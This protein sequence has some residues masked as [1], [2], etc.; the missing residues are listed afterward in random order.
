MSESAKNKLEVYYIDFSESGEKT[1]RKRIDGKKIAHAA[2]VALNPVATARFIGGLVSKSL[3][4]EI[5]VLRSEDEL[6]PFENGQGNQWIARREPGDAVQY[7]VRHPKAAKSGVLIE[8]GNF[9]KY[10]YDEYCDELINFCRSHCDAKRIV[11]SS[12]KN[13]AG[14]LDGGFKKIKVGIGAR[15][16]ASEVLNVCSPN[17]LRRVTPYGKYLWIEPQLR[18][19]I[20]GLKKGGKITYTLTQDFSFG[21][22]ASFLKMIGAKT[23]FSRSFIFNIVIE[24]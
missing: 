11:I 17:G 6:L 16:E 21:A 18:T 22:N 20:A 24:C 7:Y 23:D 14:G 15:S 13:M 5:R 4:D 12:M 19:A 10:V 1:E 3:A 2:N 8:S 9:S